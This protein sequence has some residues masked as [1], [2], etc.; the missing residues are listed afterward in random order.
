MAGHSDVGTHGVD[1]LH[2]RYADTPTPELESELL[3]RYQGLARRLA[4]RFEHRGASAEDL[5]QVALLAV[6]RALRRF[7]PSRG[8]KFSTFATPNVLG[9][10]RRHFR[11]HGW[12]VRPPR[13]VQEAYLVVH[14][15]LDV[16]EAES[17]RPPSASEV[18]DYTALPEAAVLEAVWAAGGR[19]GTSLEAPLPSHGDLSLVATLGDDDMELVATEDRMFIGHMVR[20]LPE[21][22]RR[23]VLLSFCTDLSKSEIA[24]RLGTTQQSVS[25]LRR[26]GLDLLR[27]TARAGEAAAAA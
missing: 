6:V 20:V 19:S 15:A 9:E 24:A 17:G 3:Q 27:A 12:L 21:D 7:E 1:E 5:S 4:R 18:A 23:V 2:R 10:L 14:R 13:T 25:R 11:D 26:R 16:L 8:N 22:Q